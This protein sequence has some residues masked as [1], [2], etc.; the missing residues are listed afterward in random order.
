MF[1][2]LRYTR[3]GFSWLNLLGA[4]HEAMDWGEIDQ[5]EEMTFEDI[6]AVVDIAKGQA[7][8]KEET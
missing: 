7:S 6:V 3:M 4:I 8:L 1:E 2:T 5:F